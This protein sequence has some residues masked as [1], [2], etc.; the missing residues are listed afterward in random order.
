MGRPEFEASKS[1]PANAT[2][3]VTPNARSRSST[4]LSSIV[5]I[6]RLAWL[7]ETARSWSSA[8][9][10]ETWG[11]KVQAARTVSAEPPLRA[12]AVRAPL[13]W[14]RL[15]SRG[16]VGGMSEPCQ[17][18]SKGKAGA[19]RNQRGGAACRRG[20]QL[21]EVVHA[22]IP[23]AEARMPRR[24]RAWQVDVAFGQ[25]LTVE[26]NGEGLGH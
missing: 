22:S 24:A 19:G 20:S 18:G 16:R 14:T 12:T 26:M 1:D 13:P 6:P 10:E 17:K 25:P 7:R 9:P 23:T 8:K 4:A 2:T 15:R 21:Q 11:M 5:P 3:V